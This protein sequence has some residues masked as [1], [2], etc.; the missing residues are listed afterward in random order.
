VTRGAQY[1]RMSTDH[2]KYSTENQAL[3]IAAYAAQRNISIVQSYADRGRSG[4]SI[5]RREALKELLHDVKSGHANYDVILVYDVIPN[6]INCDS[7]TIPKSVL[8]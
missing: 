3:A 5:G 2:Q 4:V 6:L 7:L 1:V 8:L